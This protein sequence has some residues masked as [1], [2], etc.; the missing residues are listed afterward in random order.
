M[1]SRVSVVS[2]SVFCPFYLHYLSGGGFIFFEGMFFNVYL[3]YLLST[4]GRIHSL[5]RHVLHQS[6]S[7]NRYQWYQEHSGQLNH[8]RWILLWIN[9]QITEW[10]R[11]LFF[12]YLKACQRWY[13]INFCLF[14]S[15]MNAM[16][17]EK[18]LVTLP[19]VLLGNF[20][21]LLYFFLPLSM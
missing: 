20:F 21:G 9:E 18:C 15:L 8:L 2:P 11:K 14:C 10:R 7:L 3:H 13:W 17:I 5:W 16:F 4:W 12:I 1:L 6:E 19:Q